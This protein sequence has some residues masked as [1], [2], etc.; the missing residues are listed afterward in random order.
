MLPFAFDGPIGAIAAKVMARLNRD[1]EAE[2][3]DLLAPAPTDHVLVIGFG[4][5]VGVKL[6]AAHLT[7]G[8]VL[9]VDPSAAMVAA[10][11][12]ANRKEIAAGQVALHAKTAEAIP[13]SDAT[14]DGA[15]AVNSLQ[16]CEPFDATARELA[17][18]LRPGARLVS[19]THDWAAARHAGSAAAWA[20]GVGHTLRL[21]GF[22]EVQDLAAKAEKGR[23]ITLIARRAI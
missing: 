6:L 16:V 2:A 21:A 5:G 3:V 14:F 4:P 22:G 8:H 9:G 13:A 17:R 23:A 18:V 11:T 10:A 19:L 1:A 15:I 7:E 20:E 12:R